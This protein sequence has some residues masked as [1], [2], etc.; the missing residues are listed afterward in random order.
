M[1][2]QIKGFDFVINLENSINVLVIENKRAYREVVNT[3][4]NELDIKNGKIL[5]SNGNELLEPYKYLFTFY[6]YYSFDINKYCLTKLYKKIRENALEEYFDETNTMKNKIEEYVY[7][8]IEDYGEYLEINGEIDIISILKS[9][10]VKIKKYSG[11]SIDKLIDYMNIIAELFNIYIFYFINLKDIFSEEELIEFYKYVRYNS[12]V[13]VLVE[14][15]KSKILE[16]EN[17]FLID[18][19]LCEIY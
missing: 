7:K 18:E 11:I 16:T 5:I 15:K 10:D 4:L 9:V 1:K 2:F 17:T 8:I 19:D 12:F 13:I 3:L 6:D 14:N